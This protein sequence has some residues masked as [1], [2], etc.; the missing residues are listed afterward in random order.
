L[1]IL[2]F[3]FWWLVPRFWQPQCAAR[4]IHFAGL[5]VLIRLIGSF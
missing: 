1:P 5:D 4:F 2:A 3:R